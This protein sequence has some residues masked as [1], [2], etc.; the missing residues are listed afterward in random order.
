MVD[1]FEDNQMNINIKEKVSEQNSKK[2]QALW[3]NNYSRY[4]NKEYRTKEEFIIKF[5]SILAGSQPS[6]IESLWNTSKE[7]EVTD[8]FNAALFFLYSSIGNNTYG[9]KL[10][11]GEHTIASHDT[12]EEPLKVYS[13]LSKIEKDDK[14]LIFL[15]EHCDLVK[16]K[17][18]MCVNED[19]VLDY[20]S[21]YKKGKLPEIKDLFKH[22]KGNH[23][24]PTKKGLNIA[25]SVLALTEDAQIF[26]KKVLE[27]KS[28]GNL[29]KQ[30]ED[31]GV[32]PKTAQE[33]ILKKLKSLNS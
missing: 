28:I 17:C 29:L 31:I 8:C 4:Y 15:N 21:L 1:N 6:L 13:T 5:I 12:L 9:K 16:E 19:N 2:A 27:D 23:L 3:N 14:D 25:I 22:I 18:I 10:K 20:I 32:T 30:L 26:A 11:F 33:A 24:T 7:F